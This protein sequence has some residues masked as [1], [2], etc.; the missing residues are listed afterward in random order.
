[1]KMRLLP[2]I[3]LARIMPKDVQEK[4]VQ[5]RQVRFG[6]PLISYNPIRSCIADILNVQP[7]V[8]E[9]RQAPWKEISKRIASQSRHKS[10]FDKNIEIAKILHNY[11]KQQQLIS[12]AQEFFPLKIG[13]STGVT[14]WWDLYYIEHDTPVVP[15]FDPRLTRGLDKD[16][17]NVVF[18]FM[19]ERVRA[20]GT[21][22]E[23]AQLTIFKFPRNADDERAL[24]IFS[25]ED[26]ELY[27]QEQ[28]EQMIIETYEIWEEVLRERELR[29]RK[30]AGQKKGSLL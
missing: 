5:L 8:F 24:K 29:V 28:L 21:D 7:G 14:F 23:N 6:S 18:S 17:R 26:A 4:R 15:F 27:S 9:A 10:E 2:P 22:L 12:Y 20:P 11:S 1:M 30:T 13:I 3:D 25:A 19:H 16:A